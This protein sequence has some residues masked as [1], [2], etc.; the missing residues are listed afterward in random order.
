MLSGALG[1]GSKPSAP[2][3]GS[4][5]PAAAPAGKKAGPLS[6]SDIV[7]VMSGITPK[8]K[9]CYEQYKVPGMANVNVKVEGSGKVSMATVTGKFA[10][11]PS[12]D[13]VEKAIKSAKFPVSDD[14]MTFPYPV[15]LR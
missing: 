5:E 15:P 8:A 10:G 6:K 14:G 9:A 4:R 7:K 13:C 1:G 2:S 3:G 11:T 12:G